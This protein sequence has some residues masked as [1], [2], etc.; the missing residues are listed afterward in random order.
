MWFY[1]NIPYNEWVMGCDGMLWVMLPSCV[2]D[3]LGGC[4]GQ[5]VQVLAK[6]A[7]VFVRIFLC[8]FYPYIV[9]LDDSKSIICCDV[10]SIFIQYLVSLVLSQCLGHSICIHHSLRF[11]GPALCVLIPTI[12][13]FIFMNHQHRGS[14]SQFIAHH[15]DHFLATCL[16]LSFFVHHIPP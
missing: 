16:F 5:V 14:Q 9:W 11:G 8:V 12:C 7:H 1:M 2:L 4:F 10:C 6:V 13:V 15:A 3:A